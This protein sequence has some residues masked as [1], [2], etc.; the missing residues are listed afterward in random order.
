MGVTGG[1]ASA[2]FAVVMV[3]GSIGLLKLAVT[4]VLSATPVAAFAGI[5]ELTVGAVVPP[6]KKFAVTLLAASMVTEQVPVPLQAPLHPV[7]LELLAGVAVSVTS[8]PLTSG[9]LV[10]VP[11]LFVQVIPPALAVTVPVPVVLTFR[12]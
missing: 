7:K 2:K 8:V 6:D 11:V 3:S 9:V 12:V 1:H 10:Q 5:V 4:S